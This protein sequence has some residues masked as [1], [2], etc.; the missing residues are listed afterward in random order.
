M[1]SNSHGFF[2]TKRNTLFLWKILLAANSK[3]KNL[4]SL[5]LI[6]GL[7]VENTKSRPK[8]LLVGFKRV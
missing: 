4:S 3:V 7:N 2:V 1:S 5:F 8:I 6:S